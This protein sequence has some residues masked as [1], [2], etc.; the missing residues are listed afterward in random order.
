ML[1]SYITFVGR[2]CCFTG[3]LLSQNLSQLLMSKI[4]A[5][6]R[7]NY[8]SLA[9]GLM[10]VHEPVVSIWQGAPSPSAFPAKH[11]G[12]KG[13]SPSPQTFR[14]IGGPP[15]G[16]TGAQVPVHPPGA[17]HAPLAAQILVFWRVL[18]S[19][20]AEPNEASAA[21]TKNFALCIIVAD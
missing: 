16:D 8:I 11:P 13:L 7:T 10:S 17:V 3:L 12:Q 18:R 2:V 21:R 1:K 6:E 14:Q 5:L 4:L 20:D 19:R 15:P 9:Q